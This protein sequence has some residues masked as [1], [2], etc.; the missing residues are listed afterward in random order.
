MGRCK[1]NWFYEHMI[2]QGLSGEN[3]NSVAVHRQYTLCGVHQM[4]TTKPW[5]RP[6][7]GYRLDDLLKKN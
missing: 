5:R 6:F 2:Y 3:D 7:S 1:H 4:A